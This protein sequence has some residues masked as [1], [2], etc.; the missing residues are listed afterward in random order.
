[1]KLTREK[2]LN[3]NVRRVVWSNGQARYLVETSGNY[4]EGVGWKDYRHRSYFRKPE[5]AGRRLGD[6]YKLKAEGYI[7]SVRGNLT[8]EDMRKLLNV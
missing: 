5:R 7:V 3:I 6:L 2:V 8:H 4:I 1:M